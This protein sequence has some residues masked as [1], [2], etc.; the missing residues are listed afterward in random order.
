SNSAD[1]SGPRHQRR[2]GALP[3][4]SIVVPSRNQ[5]P[6]LERALESLAGQGYPD[7]EVIVIDGGSTDGTAKL[8]RRRGDVVRRW[9]SEPDSGQTD[10]LN[11]GFRMATGEVFGWLNCDERY[12]PGALRR[13]GATFAAEPELEIVFGHRVVV[14]RHGRELKRMR[15][16]AIHPRRYALYAS[17]L[18]FSDTTFWKASL[19]RATGELDEENCPRYGMDFD[20]F[21]RL[22]LH[23]RRWRRIDAYLS[24]FTEHKDRI[25]KNVSEMPQIA[26]SIRKRVQRL[27]GVGPLRAMLLGL[28]YFLPVRY[29]RFGWRGLLRAPS[30]VSL[31]RVAGLIR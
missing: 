10:A 14:N 21:C 6:F 16:P 4:I 25:S 29:G 12:R 13:V 5:T 11:K 22:A 23:V 26:H 27:A 7:L 31:L 8:L 30:P 28:L 2:A 15:L 1:S 3:R 9:L 20:W 17:G 24:E 18:L 19:H